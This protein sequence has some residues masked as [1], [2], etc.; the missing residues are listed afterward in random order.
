MY[1]CV[2]NVFVAGGCLLASFA[3]AAKAQDRAS[4]AVVRICVRIYVSP[5]TSPL[6]SFFS[7]SLPPR[8]PA[9]AESARSKVGFSLGGGAAAGAKAKAKAKANANARAL[10]ARTAGDDELN[11]DSGRGVEREFITT[12]ANG[13]IE[14][15]QG[16]R[17][18]EANAAK[19]I[20]C[21]ADTWKGA[22]ESTTEAATATA[23]LSDGRKRFVPSAAAELKVGL[24]VNVGFGGRFYAD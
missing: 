2:L 9:M 4:G 5:L 7:L 21:L 20:P 17:K 23:A 16:A 10:G 1:V 19:V 24:S 18:A 3:I 22:A 8:R 15:A 13:E 11:E 14:S 6:A 12:V